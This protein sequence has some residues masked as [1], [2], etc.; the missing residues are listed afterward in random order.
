MLL[1]MKNDHNN[2]VVLRST[3]QQAEKEIAASAPQVVEEINIPLQ[4]D[5]EEQP[6]SFVEHPE[7]QPIEI[8]KP[9]ASI[10]SNTPSIDKVEKAQAS[11]ENTEKSQTKMQPEPEPKVVK[12]IA[13]EN[14]A[15]KVALS[16]NEYKIGSFGGIKNLE[17]TLQNGSTYLLEKIAVEISYLNPEGKTVGSD[18]IFFQS[19]GPGDVVTMPVKKSHRGVKV[20]MK[21]NKIESNELSAINSS[22]GDANNYSKN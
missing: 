5:F 8:Q 11:A 2:R 3:P 6:A 9:P 10:K 22:G 17:V 18:N 4:E 20:E 12:K 15:T 13:P 16:A 21:V 19:V 7:T 1:I 14:I